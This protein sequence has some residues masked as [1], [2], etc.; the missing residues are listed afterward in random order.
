MDTEGLEGYVAHQRL[1]R[2]TTQAVH[3]AFPPNLHTTERH[4]SQTSQHTAPFIDADMYI[5]MFRVE[6]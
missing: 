1:T 4:R 6:T 2:L 3:P 5:Y